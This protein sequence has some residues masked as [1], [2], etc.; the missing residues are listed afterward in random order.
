MSDGSL[1]TSATAKAIEAAI[2]KT[3]EHYGKI[4]I[5]VNGAAGNFL[6]CGQ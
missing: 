6:V 2:A 3:L 1:P 4:D 5:V